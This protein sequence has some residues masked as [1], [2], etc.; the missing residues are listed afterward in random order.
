[1]KRTLIAFLIGVAAMGAYAQEGTL[2]DML[3]AGNNRPRFGIHVDWTLSCPNTNLNRIVPTYHNGSGIT[4]GAFY[5]I[6]IYKNLYIEP[7]VNFFYNTML[8]SQDV[9]ED[10]E[11]GYPLTPE[12]SL[13]NSGIRIP[14]TFGYRFDITDDIAMSI[15]TGPQLNVG[16]SLK[17]HEKGTGQSVDL[18]DQGWHRCD[19]QWLIGVRFYYSNSWFADI[20]GGIGITNMAGGADWEGARFRRNNFSIGVGYLF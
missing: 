10:M 3:D 4:A 1:M 11:L 9:V 8:I 13:R 19:L 2:A 20:S 18:Y 14:L 6:P 5:S 17:E 15:Y 16:F 7:S 12:G